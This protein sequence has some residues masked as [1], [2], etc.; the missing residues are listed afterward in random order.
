MPALSEFVTTV[1]QERL[2]PKVID[3]IFT[4]N[5]LTMRLLKNAQLWRGGVSI[6]IPVELTKRTTVGSYSGFDTFNVSQE[7]VRQKAVFSPSQLYASVSISGIQRA[8][9]QGDAAVIDLITTELD[10]TA[11]LIRDEMGTQI[12]GDGTGN[13]GKDILGLIAAVDDGTNVAVYGGISRTTYPNWR[14]TLTAQTGDFTLANLAADFNAAQVGNEAPTLI[15]TTPAVFNIYEAL[16]TPTV[17]HQFSMNDFRLTADGIVRVGGTFAANQGFRALSFRGVPVVAD[18]KCPDGN[19]FVLNE[20]HLSFYVLPQVE[21]E[22]KLGFGW[23]GW[24][25]PV[26]QDAITGQLLW[27]GQLITDGPRYHA[28]R[29]DIVS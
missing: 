1:T 23:T 29:T 7:N 12:Y 15:I 25:E 27:Y 9:N 10:Y 24:K 28:R 20:N 5:V 14:A 13:S 3:N 8:V 21:R 2:L 22:I 17:S 26:N 16:L 6:D 18:E 19:L 11:R 4:G